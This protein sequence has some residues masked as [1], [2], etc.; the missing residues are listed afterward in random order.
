VASEG[1]RE[2]YQL[3][4]DHAQ[5]AVL[6]SQSFYFFFRDNPRLD[7]QA[8]EAL[9]RDWCREKHALIKPDSIQLAVSAL[10]SQLAMKP[11]PPVPPAPT[12]AELAA[13]EN[14]RLLAATPESLHR[15]I[16]KNDRA[17]IADA[18]VAIP[19]TAKEI[20][21]MPSRVLRSLIS[22]PNGTDRPGY[23]KAVNDI[24]AAHS[25]QRNR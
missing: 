25:A 9:I 7:L 15:E 17:R 1:I 2:E 4:N 22:Y 16:R 11:L 19:Y 14:E 8:N 10:G 21:A 23:R 18:P 24:L 12:Q 3:Q 13:K 5:N 6:A 20:L